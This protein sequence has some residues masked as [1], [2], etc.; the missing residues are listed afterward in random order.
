M[1]APPVDQ[2]Q[3]PVSQ[4][5]DSGSSQ[6]S[7]QD[8]PSYGSYED[9]P[10]SDRVAAQ[11][12][13]DVYDKAEYEGRHRFD[14]EYTW[15]AQEEKKLVRKVNAQSPSSQQD[16]TTRTARLQN[17][18]VGMDD[19]RLAGPQPQEHQPR[20]LRQHAERPQ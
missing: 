14:P 10:F 8:R 6:L 18:A 3:V 15:T 19:V 17:H 1:A 7:K 4:D 2:K 5:A 16:L 12:W 20:H 9:H 13:R 11:Y